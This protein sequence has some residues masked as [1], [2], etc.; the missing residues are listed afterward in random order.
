MQAA[1]AAGAAAEPVPHD[2]ACRLWAGEPLPVAL[3]AHAW[4]RSEHGAPLGRL[5]GEG[6]RLVL[7]SRLRR[8]GIV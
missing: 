7:P 4:V 1:I 2:L 3:P 6:L 8:G 5:D